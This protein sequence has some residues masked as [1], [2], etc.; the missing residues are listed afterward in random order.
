[1]Q[2][3][4]I[5]FRSVRCPYGRAGRNWGGVIAAD[6]PLELVSGRLAGT[7]R[8]WLGTLAIQAGPA[9]SS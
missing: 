2:S 9:R 7:R 4:T 1:M 3:R 6:S 8:V 5:R